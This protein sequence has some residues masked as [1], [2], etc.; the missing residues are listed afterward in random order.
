MHNSEE[1][2]EFYM[3][4]QTGNIQETH[5]VNDKPALCTDTCIGNFWPENLAACRWLV[6]PLTSAV[7]YVHLLYYLQLPCRPG[8]PG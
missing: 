6:T 8:V 5:C 3:S 1:H 4:L 2:A 7:T